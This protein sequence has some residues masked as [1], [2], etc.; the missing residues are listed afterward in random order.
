M[1]STIVPQFRE[2]YRPVIRKYLWLLILPALGCSGQDTTFRALAVGD[3]APDYGAPVLDA[4]SLHLRSL[5]GNPVLVNVWA[6]WCPPCR[7]EMP[8]LQALHER[9]HQRGLRV[10]G[11]SIDSRG[12]EPAVRAFLAEGGITFTILHDATDAVSRQF[13]TIGVPE[14]FL[15]DPSGHIVR[16]WI[17]RFDPLAP[18]VLRD[19]EALLPPDA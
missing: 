11:V 18:D 16:R 10:V 12:A 2:R 4:D 5:R 15:I 14:T 1:R 9:Y 8:A 13:R 7:E 3:E 17:G 19:V 6:T